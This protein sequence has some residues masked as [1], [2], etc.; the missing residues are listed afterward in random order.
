MSAGLAIELQAVAARHPAARP[1]AAPALQPTTLN[2]AEGEVLAVIGPSGAGKTTLLQALACALPPSAGRLRLDGVDPWELPRRE[3]QVLRGR[4]FLAPQVP[5]LPPRQRVVTSVLAGRLPSMGLLGSV[6]SLFYPSDIP[7]AHAALERFDLAEK[8]FERVD[9]LSG[10]ERQRVGL[11]RALLA[12]ARLWLVDEPL[13]A[14]D[15][16][17]SRQAIDTLVGEARARGVTLVATLH[18]VDVA[19]AH[20][21]RIVA[22]HQGT[23]AFDLPAAA[24]TRERLQRL[25][26]QHEHELRGDAPSAEPATPPAPVVMHCR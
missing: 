18:Q 26:A 20:F 2:V 3:L 17:R 25:Y 6:R 19:L 11:A 24:V 15:P 22:L 8:L 1:G 12:P 7:A 14:L 9:R 21:P 10:G 4:L 5:P 23:V 13:S 16:A